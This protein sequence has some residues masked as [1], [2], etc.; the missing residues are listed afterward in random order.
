MLVREKDNTIAKNRQKIRVLTMR[1]QTLI[2]NESIRIRTCHKNI[3]NQVT[4][5]LVKLVSITCFMP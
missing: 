4:F 2:S 5:I 3:A 1:K